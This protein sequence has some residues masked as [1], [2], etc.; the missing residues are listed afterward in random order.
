[1]GITKMGSPRTTKSVG[2]GAIRKARPRETRNSRGSWIRSL[3]MTWTTWVVRATS[4]L[5]RERRSPKR[6]PEW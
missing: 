5:I 3:R 1:M 2:S 6:R 4:L